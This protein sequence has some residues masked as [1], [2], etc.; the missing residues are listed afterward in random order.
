VSEFVKAFIR[1]YDGSWTC[2]T[3]ATLDEDLMPRMQVAQGA[4]FVR[5]QKFM[6]VDLAGLLDEEALEA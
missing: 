2:I 5:G 1:N 4:T 6:N 3:P